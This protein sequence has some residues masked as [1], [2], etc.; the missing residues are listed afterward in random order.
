MIGTKFSYENSLHMVVFFAATEWSK[1]AAPFYTS[2]V[3][4]RGA[5]V[6]YRGSPALQLGLRAALARM[7]QSTARLFHCP[8]TPRLCLASTTL[9]T[10]AP[11]QLT[12]R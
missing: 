9:L 11:T 1:G 8:N 3:C 5:M 7:T 2:V 12:F 4:Q 10:Q 6:A